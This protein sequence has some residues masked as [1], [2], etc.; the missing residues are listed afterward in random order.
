MKKGRVIRSLLT[1]VMIF[2]ITSCGAAMESADAM[3]MN[4]T[5][6]AEAVRTTAATA[7]YDG[8]LADDAAFGTAAGSVTYSYTAD[9]A[10]G[11]SAPTGT[12][13]VNDLAERKIIK[14]ATVRYE[15]KTY[16]EFFTGLTECIRKY[17]A[18]VES[19]ESYGGSLYDYYSTRCAYL[20][21]RVP[22]ATY[23]AFMSEA[24]SIGTVTYKSE[25]STDVTMAYVDTES[26]ITSLETEYDALL[27]ILEKASKLEDVISLQSRISEVTY[28]LETYKAQLRKY[29]DLIS[30]CTVSIDVTEVEK[31]TQNISEMTFGEKIRT[32]LTETFEN[33]GSDAS[34][35]A[36]WF[37]T[38]LPYFL[39]W[40]VF[41]AA[42]IAVLYLLIVRCRKRRILRTPEPPDD[43]AQQ[44][45]AELFD[46]EYE[47]NKP[48]QTNL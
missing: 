8:K 24:C 30:Y 13:G 48:D 20:T 38:S 18:Y 22:L 3:V 25:N 36:V 2:Q 7:Y 12:A 41:L 11:S 37:V 15:T 28:E 17:G 9:S 40:G 46:R 35:F 39:I 34:D 44:E 26:R 10:S 16:D 42:V 1:L 29:D 27:A 43:S 33:I 47:N 31:V 5:A 21:V 32:G 6:P 19:E 23:D 14:N 4:E 45:Q